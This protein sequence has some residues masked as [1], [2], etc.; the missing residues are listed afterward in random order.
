ML[1]DD[2]PI[3]REGLA[4]L[5]ASIPGFV[6]VA[7]AGDGTEA[8]A[9]VPEADPDVIVM[10]VNMPGLDGIE[11]TRRIV[12]DHPHIGVVVL[13]MADGDETVFRAMRAGARGYLL[14]GA[15]QEEISRA[16]RSV[17][18]GDAIFGPNIAARIGEFF[19]HSPRSDGY[20]FPQ[21]TAREREILDLVA[22][23][24]SNPQIAEQLFLAP[25]TVR[26]NVANIFVKLQV[27]SRSE[28]VIAAR[29]AG[30]G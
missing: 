11:A 16:I 19:S 18:S 15:G 2:H 14:K 6:V 1:V 9:A 22:A 17:A 30:L 3:Y 5:L 13:T 12:A 20:A 10:D 26:N 21:L 27:S 23:G 4:A 7:T 24:R 8:V 29:E 28:A 25:K